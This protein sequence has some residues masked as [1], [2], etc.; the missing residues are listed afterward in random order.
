MNYGYPWQEKKNMTNYA[1]Q[2]YKK[3]EEQGNNCD[4]N[5]AT[6]QRDIYTDLKNKEAQNGSKTKLASKIV[7]CF[8]CGHQ[9]IPKNWLSKKNDIPPNSNVP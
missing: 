1:I 9:D 3:R 8:S 7:P 5:M 6:S 4:Q 2:S